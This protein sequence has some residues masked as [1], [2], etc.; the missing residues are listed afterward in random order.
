M[1]NEPVS[2]RRKFHQ[3]QMHRRAAV[4]MIRRL[5]TGY[6]LFM[7]AIL[8]TSITRG[9]VGNLVTQPISPRLALY[10]KENFSTR[11]SSATSSS[12]ISIPR[13]PTCE[14]ECASL[15]RQ[16][17]KAAWKPAAR[18]ALIS[19]SNGTSPDRWLG[20][21]GGS[22]LSLRIGK[23]RRRRM[24]RRS[25]Q[26]SWSLDRSAGVRRQRRSGPAGV[27]SG[28]ARAVSRVVRRRVRAS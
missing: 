5:Q 23:S 1:S 22:G 6:I 20:H 9:I 27:C 2:H 12:A 10:R 13:E 14:S 7:N 21:K 24:H 25:W 19:C 3:S 17:A 8:L 18:A 28:T 4:P 16:R 11:L 15:N 26:L